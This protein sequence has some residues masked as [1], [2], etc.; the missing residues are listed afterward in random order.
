MRDADTEETVTRPPGDR[1]DVMR[2]VI[3]GTTDAVF[4]KDL[5]GRYL[6][7]NSACARFIGRPASE[8]VGRLDA[9]LYPP[10][11]ARQFTEA[12][13]EVLASG[14]TRVFE[15]VAEG[16]RG[17]QDYRVT[18]GVVRDREGRTVGL[19]GI[20]HDITDRRAA[21]E[22]RARRI[23]EQAARE[24]AEA[25]GRAKDDLLRA[26]GESEERYRAFIANSSE[27]IWR[28]EFERPIPVALPEDEQI[29][30][31]YEHCYLAECNDAA[32]RMYGFER[33][34]E[35][36]GAR[37]ADFL[38]RDDPANVEYLRAF[39]RSGYKLADAESVEVDREGRTRHFLNSLAGTVEG[40]R[41]VRVWGT[42]RDVTERKRAEEKLRA[43][44]N[45]SESLLGSP[46]TE[47]VLSATLKLAGRLVRADAYAIWRRRE[48]A[49]R[50]EVVSS[51]GLSDEY[52]ES[53]IAVN[54]ETPSM[55]ESPVIVEDV[56][57]L[58]LL[59]ERRE[60]YRR[61]GIR[62]LLALP[63]KVHGQVAG[64]LVF[65]YR[66]PRRFAEPDVTV[67]AAIANLSASAV[68]TAELYEEQSRLRGEA[69]A[70]SR[71]A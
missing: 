14:Q 42:Q 70:A 2:A 54:S 68:G 9:D 35:M 7:V 5:E 40:G 44:V 47:A 13:R 37:L 10:D 45:A 22:E 11:T 71:R 8:I 16:A 12:D 41:L 58:P 48:G 17:T 38:V 24:E 66:E 57:A 36:T 69:E 32:A 59:A 61:E 30:L 56:D 31:C 6:L 3:E 55:P 62:S 50:W 53:W 20:S 49:G 46:R 4:V 26:L 1:D 33:A 23:R 64:T 28:F 67:A 18:K 27:G 19:F 34:E 52:R 25:S 51:E 15:G 43:L 63:L 65:Y 60:A 39:I 21:E 29:E